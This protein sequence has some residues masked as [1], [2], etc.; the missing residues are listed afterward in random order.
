M[1]QT[2]FL[3]FVFLLCPSSAGAAGAAA[4][5]EGG[6]PKHRSKNGAVPIRN[7]DLIPRTVMQHAAEKSSMPADRRSHPHILRLRACNALR[8]Q[9]LSA[10]VSLLCEEPSSQGSQPPKVRKV[11]PHMLV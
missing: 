6:D 7:S 4:Y 3:R 5:R 1:V 2:R 9:R 11:F 10:P 8:L